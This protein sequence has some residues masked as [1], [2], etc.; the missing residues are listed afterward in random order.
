[1][2]LQT[3]MYV[4]W[5][6]V[7]HSVLGF[8]SLP[9]NLPDSKYC[10][11][12]DWEIGDPVEWEAGSMDDI[13][14]AYKE[15]FA[16][17]EQFH[18]LVDEVYRKHPHSAVHFFK[19]FS[20]M[21]NYETVF[22]EPYDLN[23]YAVP[24]NNPDYCVQLV[25]AGRGFKRHINLTGAPKEIVSAATDGEGSERSF[26][27][28]LYDE[29]VNATETCSQLNVDLKEAS[30]RLFWTKKLW[31]EK[32]AET[33]ILANVRGHPSR[34][35]PNTTSEFRQRCYLANNIIPS[36]VSKT[37][38]SCNA[39][40]CPVA[41]TEEDANICPSGV[42]GNT[43]LSSSGVRAGPSA[44]PTNKDAKRK[45]TGE[46]AKQYIINE[47]K[48][49]IKSRPTEEQFIEIKVLP[50]PGVGRQN[51]KFGTMKIIVFTVY[52]NAIVRVISLLNRNIPENGYFVA[53]SNLIGDKRFH[54]ASD[55]EPESWLPSGET[56]P[57]GILLITR[58]DDVNSE[59]WEKVGLR[60]HKGSNYKQNTLDIELLVALKSLVLDGQ[61]YGK[62]RNQAISQEIAEMFPGKFQDCNCIFPI[63][64]AIETTGNSFNLCSN[65]DSQS[66]FQFLKFKFGKPT[67][68]SENN[69]EGQFTY[70]CGEEITTEVEELPICPIELDAEYGY[71]KTRIN[72]EIDYIR[73]H[74]NSTYQNELFPVES[75]IDNVWP[76]MQD[77]FGV[78]YSLKNVL[79]FEF[80]PPGQPNVEGSGQYFQ[81]IR[82]S[83]C[84]KRKV[85]CPASMARPQ[86]MSKFTNSF[87]IPTTLS[88]FKKM[89]FNHLRS[90]QHLTSVL[91]DVQK[92]RNMYTVDERDKFMTSATSGN[93]QLA[94]LFDVAFT[95]LHTNTALNN[96]PIWYSTLKKISADIGDSMHSRNTAF[97][98]VNFIADT[99]S[100]D[101]IAYLIQK[102]EPFTLILDGSSDALNNHY[103]IVYVQGLEGEVTSSYFLFLLT[104]RKR[105]TAE[106]YLEE[107]LKAIKRTS[108][109][110]ESYFRRRIVAIAT[111]SARVME[112][113]HSDL[114]TWVD[115]KTFDGKPL[116]LISIFCLA[117]RLQLATRNAFAPTKSDTTAPIGSPIHYFS[118]LEKWM[119]TSYTYFRWS[120]RRIGVFREVIV[121][122]QLPKTEFKELHTERWIS[123]EY[124]TVKNF[125]TAWT[126]ARLSLQQI[127]DDPTIDAKTKQ[128][129][130]DM[131]VRFRDKTALITLHFL[132]D[133]TATFKIW[134]EHLQL[135]IGVL[136]DQYKYF[137]ELN[138]NINVLKD[139]QTPVITNFLKECICD[140][141]DIST[142]EEYEACEIVDWN[143]FQFESTNPNAPT[144]HA[145]AEALIISVSAKLNHYIPQ[146]LLSD[147]YVLS[148]AKLPLNI[149]ALHTQY[150]LGNPNSN[151]RIYAADEVKRLAVLI[152]MDPDALV[153]DW[154]ELI[155]AMLKSKSWVSNRKIED[156]NL[157]WAAQ[158]RENLPWTP[159]TYTF[160]RTIK[161]IA[162]GSVT[163][164]TGFS[165]FN[166]IKTKKR[167]NIHDRHIENIM[168]ILTN[169]PESIGKFDSYKYAERWVM[170]GRQRPKLLSEQIAA[171]VTTCPRESNDEIEEDE[172]D[173]NDGDDDVLQDTEED[174]NFEFPMPIQGTPITYSDAYTKKTFTSKSLD[175]N[176]RQKSRIRSNIM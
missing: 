142:V 145:A 40:T 122:Q 112:K 137:N 76:L 86:K 115:R 55:F 26:M 85:T 149:D 123:S 147:A 20:A 166:N 17:S 171:E 61:V 7:F 144:F 51:T 77:N 79:P 97:G 139:F 170:A 15:G 159:R 52:S 152:G 96:A 89:L 9:F 151:Q 113:F 173:V 21:K 46:D 172:P 164:E 2:E 1:M 54:R 37:L 83:L 66:T 42:R 87:D 103:V 27:W 158:L 129:V 30:S 150:P 29:W 13:C 23:V 126:T 175:K 93:Q 24:S 44:N 57:V 168:K 47:F 78:L 146:Q 48:P 165:I 91:Y 132:W 70:L 102:D 36:V 53:S 39:K 153:I 41:S 90:A 81:K 62:V 31:S 98:M 4:M 140:D 45:S 8:P 107:L 138:N 125:V 50:P 19:Y 35:N 71:L 28:Y 131:Q 124:S 14:V 5:A 43:I 73:K 118:Y 56:E 58:G 74:F 94:N 22:G 75:F 99:G 69:C 148:P 143:N 160:M 67:P 10:S 68:G 109:E 100:Q 106:A 167:S 121:E 157:F 141:R 38:Q 162:P 169:G 117:H 135:L 16:T 163:C 136:I 63:G 120:G 60:R 174:V 80:L 105:F 64:S 133:F 25:Y 49:Y 108:P 84:N 34:F 127:E 6:C 82:C 3:L 92:D 114:S 111:D 72:S 134:S 116:K 59:V 176:R 12:C 11:A 32:N 155:E 161:V 130:E 156:A 128:G 95:L 33:A 104:L 88:I 154:M 101:I 18:N 65:E 110:F 119:Q